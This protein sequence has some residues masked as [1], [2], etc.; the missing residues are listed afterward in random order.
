M[1]NACCNKLKSTETPSSAILLLRFRKEPNI[2]RLFD[3]IIPFTVLQM[4]NRIPKIIIAGCWHHV[5]LVNLEVSSNIDHH[6]AG[7]VERIPQFN[8]F[9]I[10]RSVGRS[11]STTAAGRRKSNLHGCKLAV[12]QCTELVVQVSKIPTEL[13]EQRL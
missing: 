8:S 11:V 3:S 10:Y 5:E 4:L 1:Q 6:V 13:Q 2:T 12:S 9:L 7:R